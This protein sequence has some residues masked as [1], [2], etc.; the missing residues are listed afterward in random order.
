MIIHNFWAVDQTGYYTCSWSWMKTEG[1]GL[2]MNWNWPTSDNMVINPYMNVGRIPLHDITTIISTAS[3][4]LKTL[5]LENVLLSTRRPHGRI[6]NLFWKLKLSYTCFN[7]T[8]LPTTHLWNK[9]RVKPPSVQ[10]SPAQTSYAP[11]CKCFKSCSP[12]SGLVTRYGPQATNEIHH[13]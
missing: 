13:A 7:S 11:F 6:M 8:S 1:R 3:R 12:M 9:A 4:L 10:T 5:I 2:S